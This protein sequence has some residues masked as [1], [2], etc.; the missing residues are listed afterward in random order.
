[1]SQLVLDPEREA[2]IELV[3]GKARG[4]LTLKSLEEKLNE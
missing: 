2:P 4:I 3:G 1:M